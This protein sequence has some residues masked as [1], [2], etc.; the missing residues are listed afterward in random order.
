MSKISIIAAIAENYG[1]GFENSLLCH[2]PADLKHFKNITIGHTIIMGK[3]TYKSLPNGALPNRKNIVLSTTLEKN[4]DKYIQATSLIEAINLCKNEEQIFIIGGAKVFNEAIHHP[5][6][7]T[8]YITWIH[9]SDFEADV[10]F[11]K[12]EKKEWKEI[13][14][15]PHKA[16]DNNPYDYTFIIYERIKE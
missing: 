16:D 8:M 4:N 14:R 2:L 10:F 13:S 6:V 11:P 5:K 15:E 9:S 12:I 1:I 3:W 7:N